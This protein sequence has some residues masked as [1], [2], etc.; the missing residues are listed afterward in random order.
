MQLFFNEK[1]CV[2]GKATE[3]L[4][5]DSMKG[6]CWC[7]CG[8]P[9]VSAFSG[10]EG[11]CKRARIQED[12]LLLLPARKELLLKVQRH[13]FYLQALF[14]LALS[15]I[16]GLLLPCLPLA[17]CHTCHLSCSSSVLDSGLLSHSGNNCCDTQV[18]DICIGLKVCLELDNT[19]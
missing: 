4:K 17:L 3:R 9:H 18:P 15:V 5:V 10:S 14:I 11:A 13:V 16:S 1:P 8:E 12:A 19:H 7:V 2:C 6:Q